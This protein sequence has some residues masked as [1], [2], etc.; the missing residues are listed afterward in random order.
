MILHLIGS[1]NGSTTDAGSVFR[2][3]TSG[4]SSPID[5]TCSNSYITGPIIA[6]RLLVLVLRGADSDPDAP[7][8]VRHGMRLNTA[9][10][11]NTLLLLA[12][13]AL[14]AACGKEPVA[15][16]PTRPVLTRVLGESAGDEFLDYSGE[17]RSRYEIPLA[18]RIPGKISARLVDTGAVVKAGEV[19][20]RLD[21]ADT[22]LAATAASAQ[23]DLAAADLGRFRNLHARNFVSQAALDAQETRFRA[24]LAQAE[25]ARNQ[26]A[27]TVLRAEQ[28]GIVGFVTAEV[29]QVVAAGQTVMRLARADTLEVAISIP[30]THMPELRALRSAEVSLWAENEAIY[31]GTLRE[32]SAVADP[33][34]RSYA[35][36]VSIHHPDARVLLGMTARVHFHR[37]DEKARLTVPLS[38]IF[39]HA[40]QP[41]L[42]VV[43]AEK[44]VTLRPV[45]IA[46]YREDAAVL[47]SGVQAGE[48]IVVAGV[49][50][51][52]S[53][54]H[55]KVIEQAPR[56]DEPLPEKDRQGTYRR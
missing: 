56:F 53:G 50:K 32:V 16:E 26:T 36:R 20:A 54:E 46:R 22:T 14:L 28:A 48:R 4:Q 6:L 19:L 12:L 49:H 47:D 44:T 29:G 30:E 5:S 31:L 39:Q 42:W 10:P 13:L 43:S 24:A 21:P 51:L 45:A 9:F 18:F 15:P 27:Y 25:L 35:A 3:I 34:T 38:A 55:V 37:P 40:G 1:T 8:P 2:R 11:Q 17:V 52:S 7:L 23:L 33:V 41:A